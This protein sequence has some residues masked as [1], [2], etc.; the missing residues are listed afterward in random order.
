M[1]WGGQGGTV[2]WT[3]VPVRQLC[4]PDVLTTVTTDDKVFRLQAWMP[5]P[6]DLQ[7]TRCLMDAEFLHHAR[8]ALAA[9]G[10]LHVK[11][12]GTAPD[13]RRK[14]CCTEHSWGP[15][16]GGVVVLPRWKPPGQAFHSAP[17]FAEI[18]MGG[19]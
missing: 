19:L 18:R 3:L 15:R 7:V 11:L 17:S 4:T 5:G 12:R 8:Q 1:R 13:K 14:S 10:H 9:G 6:P 16:G 2:Q